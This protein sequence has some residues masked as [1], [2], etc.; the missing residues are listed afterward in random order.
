MSEDASKTCMRPNA[1][2][3]P[4]TTPVHVFLGQAQQGDE[5]ASTKQWVKEGLIVNDVHKTLHQVQLDME[6]REVGW[7]AASK[8]LYITSCAML[9]CIRFV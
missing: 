7:Y 6:V 4:S 5:D 2:P 8:T 9:C 1:D 3:I